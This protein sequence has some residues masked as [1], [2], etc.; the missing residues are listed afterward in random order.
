MVM[1]LKSTVLVLITSWMLIQKEPMKE[2]IARDGKT[3]D[4]NRIIVLG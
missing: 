3:V 1:L 2:I 4:F